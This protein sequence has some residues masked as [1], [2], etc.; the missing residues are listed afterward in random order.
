M[1]E[2]ERK[3][4]LESEQAAAQVAKEAMKRDAEAIELAK[5]MQHMENAKYL[6]Y[7]N[8]TR[9]DAKEHDSL[10]KPTALIDD[11]IEEAET[12]CQ[13]KKQQLNNLMKVCIN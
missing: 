7:L 5:R 3:K 4:R 10:L 13:M 11:E 8:K 9:C 1:E 6:Q 12:K 2:Y